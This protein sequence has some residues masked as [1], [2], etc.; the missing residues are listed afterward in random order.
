ME[1]AAQCGLS[2]I[3]KVESSRSVFFAASWFR[4]EVVNNLSMLTCVLLR[5]KRTNAVGF[6]RSAIH[7]LDPSHIP[8]SRM[9]AHLPGTAPSLQNAVLY[10]AGVSDNSEP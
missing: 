1:Y 6:L 5:K 3:R 7:M 10:S 9:W 8:Y 4:V 2:V